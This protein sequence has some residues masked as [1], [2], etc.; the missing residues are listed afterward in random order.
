MHIQVEQGKYQT[1][2][3]PD[4]ISSGSFCTCYVVGVWDKRL[5]GA[6]IL[7]DEASIN[8]QVLLKFLDMILAESKM[9]DLTIRVFGGGE[10]GDEHQG[11]IYDN[12]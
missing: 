5:R 8:D 1:V 10:S 2:T 11:Y 6:H 3:C 9:A 7:H 4:T 12:R